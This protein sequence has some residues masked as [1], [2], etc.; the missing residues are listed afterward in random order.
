MSNGTVSPTLHFARFVVIIDKLF[1]SFAD[2]S[3]SL[4]I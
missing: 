3:K 4:V 1:S 2:W